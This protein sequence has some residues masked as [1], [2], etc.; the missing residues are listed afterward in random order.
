MQT[1]SSA[2]CKLCSHGR[3]S[4]RHCFLFFLCALRRRPRGSRR[5]K[6]TVTSTGST[7]CATSTAWTPGEVYLS[8]CKQGHLP[9]SD[10]QEKEKAKAT[11]QFFLP[12]LLRNS[13]CKLPLLFSHHIPLRTVSSSGMGEHFKNAAT[14]K[15]LSTRQ[16]QQEQIHSVLTRVQN[17]QQKSCQSQTRAG[18]SLN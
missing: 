11:L 4:I 7:D 6:S 13:T 17:V 5:N 2:C 1:P 10:T 8:L 3:R 9:Y 18:S 12:N 16:K 14:V 15:K